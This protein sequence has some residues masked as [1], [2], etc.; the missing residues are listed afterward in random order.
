MRRGGLGIRTGATGASR[1]GKEGERGRE[2]WRERA[3]GIE[4]EGERERVSTAL[5]QVMVEAHESVSCLTGA[6]ASGFL[7]AGAAPAWGGTPPSG[8]YLCKYIYIYI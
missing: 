2:G 5:S 7:A 4:R 6:A 1:L 3:R 8:V